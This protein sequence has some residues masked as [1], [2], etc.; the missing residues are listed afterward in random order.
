[1][2][3]PLS[4]VVVFSPNIGGD[5]ASPVWVAECPFSW[6]TVLPPSGFGDRITP[7]FVRQ[8]D[9]KGPLIRSKTA[10]FSDPVV[11][12]EAEMGQ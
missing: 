10:V 5:T 3:N 8:S 11:I 6:P 12:F 4:L 9:P 7:E 1:V 2:L